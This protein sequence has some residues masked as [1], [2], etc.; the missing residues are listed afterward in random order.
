MVMDRDDVDAGAAQGLEHRLYLGL[1]HDEIAIDDGLR[2][3]PGKSGPGIDAHGVADLMAV[4]LRGAS[5][6][7][8]VDAIGQLALDPE[9]VL[10]RL[11]IQG[12]LRG[13][14]LD[15]RDL[16]FAATRVLN[17][18]LVASFAIFSKLL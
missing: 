10:N 13:A 2:I 4:H 6:G 5:D 15:P 7:D 3:A 11:G 1:K 17:L 14:E 8:L 18:G 16:A 12:R 9:D